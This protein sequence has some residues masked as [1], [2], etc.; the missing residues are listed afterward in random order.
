M[1]ISTDDLP[2]ELIAQVFVEALGSPGHHVNPILRRLLLVCRRW[3]DIA[4]GTPALW[5]YIYFRLDLVRDQASE[6][7]AHITPI[8]VPVTTVYNSSLSTSRTA[9]ISFALPLLRDCRTAFL[10]R[11]RSRLLAPTCLY[12]WKTVALGL[13]IL[14]SFH[15]LEELLE[16]M[17][18]PLPDTRGWICPRL[19][20]HHRSKARTRQFSVAGDVGF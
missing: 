2:T 17:S 19:P 3:R 8:W 18:Q 10:T 14:E 13:W 12:R 1:V 5:Q 9:G 15:N 11:R 20:A 16:V 7:R 6:A 4:Y